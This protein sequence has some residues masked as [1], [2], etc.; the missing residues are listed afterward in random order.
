MAKKSKRAD[1]W[2]VCLCPRCGRS[3]TRE[4]AAWARLIECANDNTAIACYRCSEE[5][6]ASEWA[7][8]YE[9]AQFMASGWKTPR[10]VREQRGGM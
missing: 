3:N 5:S 2:I 7:R 1:L 9:R 10:M 6:M 4:R 8:A